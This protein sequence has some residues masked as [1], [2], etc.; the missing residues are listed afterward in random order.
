[1]S[2]SIKVQSPSLK[3]RW[4]LNATWPSLMKR[5]LESP[6]VDLSAE[7][8]GG[9]LSGRADLRPGT[10]VDDDKDAAAAAAALDLLDPRRPTLTKLPGKAGGRFG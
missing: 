2:A 10:G 3:G 1:M 7:G 9:A 8:L 5:D 6:E 4:C